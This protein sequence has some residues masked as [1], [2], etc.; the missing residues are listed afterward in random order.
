MKIQ[1]SFFVI[2]FFLSS[3][4]LIRPLYAYNDSYLT[5]G[6]PGAIGKM[7]PGKAL[8]YVIRP[9]N[10]GY[11]TKTWA[12]VDDKPVG[13]NIGSSYFFTH[14][15]PGKHLFWSIGARVQSGYVN[16][17]AGKTYYI[18]Q[19]I[20]YGGVKIFYVSASRSSEWIKTCEMTEL[21]E[22]GIAR[23]TFLGAKRFEY[24]KKISQEKL[25]QHE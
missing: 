20:G 10:A 2:I 12:F 7:I 8:V 15:S 9:S 3:F 1:K 25:E 24:A 16:F 21:T 13:A 4:F 22:K 18:K 5:V 6:K 17:E 14:V 11:L 23:G 19:A